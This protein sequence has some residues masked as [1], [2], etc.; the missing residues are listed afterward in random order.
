V[1][2]YAYPDTDTNPD[3]DA[4]SHADAYPDTDADTYA[5]RQHDFQRV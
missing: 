4:Y 2:R 3:T 5:S 1:R